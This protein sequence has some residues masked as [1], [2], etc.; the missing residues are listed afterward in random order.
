MLHFLVICQE[1]VNILVPIWAITPVMGVFEMSWQES[2][3][4]GQRKL[5]L[6][7]GWDLQAPVV[8]LVTHGKPFRLVTHHIMN[9]N[10]EFQS[11]LGPTSNVGRT[12]E[13]P[14]NFWWDWRQG[15]GPQQG[16]QLEDHFLVG[17]CF[18]K[19]P[20]NANRHEAKQCDLCYSQHLHNT[21]TH[22]CVYGC[23]AST[24]NS[25]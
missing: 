24:S 13:L 12:S 1:C 6:P 22:V 5:S 8:D 20:G 9:A 25:L 11:V 14:P 7:K 15:E 23:I 4:C 17:S 10:E 19:L 3:N 18:L 2:L 16:C 21:V